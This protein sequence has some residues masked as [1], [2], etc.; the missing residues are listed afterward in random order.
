MSQ[1]LTIAVVS[2]RTNYRA[3]FGPLSDERAEAW[4]DF[5]HANLPSGSPEEVDASVAWMC[6]TWQRDQKAP[7][8]RDIIYAVLRRR[9][10]G[11]FDTDKK[12]A[13][14]KQR[15]QTATPAERWEIICEPNDVNDCKALEKFAGCLRGGFERP[16]WPRL[17]RE[18]RSRL[19]GV[20]TAGMREG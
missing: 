2:W 11:A 18:A 19:A 4:E 16:D 6:Q 9:G 5:M 15:L 20:M 13:G 10:S 1:G 14:Y 8:V 7:T 12:L 3:C 17:F